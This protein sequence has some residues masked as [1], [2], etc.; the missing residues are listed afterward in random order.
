MTQS[1]W[2]SLAMMGFCFYCLKV[3]HMSVSFPLPDLFTSLHPAQPLFG[4][5]F[6]K[7]KYATITPS[8]K[9]TPGIS[10]IEMKTC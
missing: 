1:L 4:S 5:F 7:I 2:K 8:T 3:L 9:C 6:K 10:P